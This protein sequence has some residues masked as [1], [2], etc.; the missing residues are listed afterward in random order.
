MECGICLGPCG[1]PHRVEFLVMLVATVLI[2][3]C[4]SLADM[5][6]FVDCQEQFLSIGGSGGRHE[7]FC[8]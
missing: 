5:S 1:K 6:I 3:G 4:P 7:M 2:I 8:S